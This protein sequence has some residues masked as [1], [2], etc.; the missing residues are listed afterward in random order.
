VICLCGKEGQQVL[1]GQ[2]IGRVG[3]TCFATGSHLHW[4][5]IVGSI[6][7]DPYLLVEKDPLDIFDRETG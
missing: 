7:V 4:G 2:D 6:F 5:A 1:K 3:S